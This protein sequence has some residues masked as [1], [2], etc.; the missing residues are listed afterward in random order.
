M[1]VARYAGAA[2]EEGTGT[3]PDNIAQDVL[4]QQNLD[5][6]IRLRV[7]GAH[8]SE[9]AASCG[10]S[11]PAAALRAVGEAM[12]SATARTEETA[13][14]MRDTAN[15]RLESLLKSTLDM[16]DADAPVQYD[17]DGN[18]L[19][20]DD[21]AVKLRAVDEARRLVTD[22]AKLNG[23][24]KPAKDTGSGDDVPTIRI[25]GLDPKDLV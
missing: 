25:V 5:R 23:V 4:D 24:D 12:A 17:A 20:S 21:R 3:M 22:L 10:F 2:T 8:W 19:S 15:L 6:A 18:E 1:S 14:Q 7:R 16:L 13:D 9:I 11:S